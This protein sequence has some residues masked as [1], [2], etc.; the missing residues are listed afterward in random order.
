MDVSDSIVFVLCL[1]HVTTNGSTDPTGNVRK[2]SLDLTSHVITLCLEIKLSIQKPHVDK[3]TTWHGSQAPPRASVHDAVHKGQGGREVPGPLGLTYT[4]PPTYP[5][6]ITLSVPLYLLIS[7]L[8]CGRI[9]LKTL[10]FVPPEHIYWN[11]LEPLKSYN[12]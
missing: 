9:G 12:E 5:H 1:Y 10:D 11:L 7:V 8:E 3:E 4:Y 6:K 2:C